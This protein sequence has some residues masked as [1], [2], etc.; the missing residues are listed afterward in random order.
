[1]RARRRHRQLPVELPPAE[2]PGKAS[3]TLGD[4]DAGSGSVGDGV[5]VRIEALKRRNPAAKQQ[6]QRF[7]YDENKPLRLVPETE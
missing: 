5:R 3:A 1:V 4:A 2:V 7:E 6:K